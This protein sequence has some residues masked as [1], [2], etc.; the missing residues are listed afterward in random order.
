MYDCHSLVEAAGNPGP[1][2]RDSSAARIQGSLAAL[3]NA[4]GQYNFD[5]CVRSLQGI[6]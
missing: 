4:A 2:E 3:G 5:M 6:R 1:E